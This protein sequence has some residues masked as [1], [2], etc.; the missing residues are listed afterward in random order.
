MF[1]KRREDRGSRDREQYH[2][3]IQ[4]SVK[5]IV[6][7]D[8]HHLNNCEVESSPKHI[9]DCLDNKAVKYPS[10]LQ[11]KIDGLKLLDI[12]DRDE[13]LQSNPPFL[14]FHKGNKE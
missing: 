4:Y 5:Q 2:I 9:R 8:Q 12:I 14:S 13:N 6:K 3:K 10:S 1:Y 11:K 7:G